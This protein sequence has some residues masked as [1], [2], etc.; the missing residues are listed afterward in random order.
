M[1]HDQAL[2]K[3]P[4]SKVLRRVADQYH[5]PLNNDNGQ[6]RG[7]VTKT[8]L[9]MG[10]FRIQCQKSLYCEGRQLKIS[11]DSEQVISKKLRLGDLADLLLSHLK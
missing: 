3:E 11:D 7:P 5:W 9:E 10:P 2:F 1:Y 4:W 8:P 6:L